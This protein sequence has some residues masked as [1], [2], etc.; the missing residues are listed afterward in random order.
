[1][2]LTL[3]ESAGEQDEVFEVEGIHFLIATNKKPYFHQTKLDYVKG[4]FGGDFKLL[5]V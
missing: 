3:E 4:I 5:R 1:M 2:E